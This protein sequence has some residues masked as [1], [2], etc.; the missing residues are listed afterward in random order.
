MKVPVQR[1]PEHHCNLSSRAGRGLEFIARGVRN[2]GY[3]H[4]VVL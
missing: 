4:V 3:E 2:R 1:C